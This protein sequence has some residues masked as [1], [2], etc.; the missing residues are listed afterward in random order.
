MRGFAVATGSRRGRAVD[1]CGQRADL[2][3]LELE[4]KA[5]DTCLCDTIES[6]P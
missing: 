5:T 6:S 1:H 2:Q 3:V 4:I